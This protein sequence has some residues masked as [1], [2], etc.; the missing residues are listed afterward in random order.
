M[1]RKFKNSLKKVVKSYFEMCEHNWALR[2][3]GNVWI[4]PEL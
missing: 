4:G 2:T 3:T 1:I